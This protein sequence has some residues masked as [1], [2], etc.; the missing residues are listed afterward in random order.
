MKVGDL[1]KTK[2][3]PWNGTGLVIDLGFHNVTVRWACGTVQEVDYRSLEI[4][5][6]S[7]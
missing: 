1:V 4:L 3:D 6:E 7:R 5:S 2:T